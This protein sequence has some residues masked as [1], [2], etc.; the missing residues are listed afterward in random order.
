MN[1]VPHSRHQINSRCASSIVNPSGATAIV[2]SGRT[3]HSQQYHPHAVV[4]VKHHGWNNWRL[5]TAYE[6][7]MLWKQAVDMAMSARADQRPVE[8]RLG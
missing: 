6:I 5:R 8:R 2:D 1:K 3:I 4:A 7:G